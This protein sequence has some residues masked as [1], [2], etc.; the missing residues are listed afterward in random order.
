MAATRGGYDPAM[1]DI[2]DVMVTTTSLAADLR[3]VGVASGDVLVLH[4]SLRSMGYVCGGAVAVLDAVA[5]ALGPDGTLVMP[6]HSSLSDPSHWVNP[7]VPEAWWETIRAEMP[8]YDPAVTPCNS[9]G[10]VAST[11]LRFPGTL[12]SA[13]PC[14]S[15]SARGPRAEEI[16][17]PH[18]LEHEM[19][20][21]SP[22]GRAYALGAKVLLLGVGHDRNTSL[23]LAEARARFPGKRTI[24]QGSPVV[25]DG[26]R[27]WARYDTLD[28]D[29][30]DFAAIGAAFERACPD[31]RTGPAG[32][33][34]AR[35]MPQRALVDFGVAWMEAN[36]GVTPSAGT[37]RS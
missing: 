9:I 24:L 35:L 10:V 5:R 15:F 19:D 8:P 36:R 30:D 34:V 29:S 28:W 23:H 12:R 37:A 16:L 22:L 3:A 4:A 26:R 14:S 27:V 33:A 25:R 31:V 2:P 1:D 11:F 21:G 32:A 13:H 17:R 20:D 6:A 7:P 18:P